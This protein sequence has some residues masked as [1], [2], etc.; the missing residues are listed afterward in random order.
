MT[1]QVHNIEAGDLIVAVDFDRPDR[2]EM[3]FLKALTDLLFEHFGLDVEPE[4]VALS[5]V[6]SGGASEHVA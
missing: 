1:A 3:A 4:A 6:V 5:V 2:V